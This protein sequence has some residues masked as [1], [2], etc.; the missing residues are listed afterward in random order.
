MASKIKILN[1]RTANPIPAGESSRLSSATLVLMTR[2]E[3]SGLGSAHWPALALPE[4][5][6]PLRPCSAWHRRLDLADPDHGI[7]PCRWPRLRRDSCAALGFKPPMTFGPRL[8]STIST[9]TEAPGHQRS[10]QLRLRSFSAQHQRPIA[11]LDD[12]AR[13]AFD[14]A[15]PDGLVFGNRVLQRPPVLMTANIVFPLCSSLPMLAVSFN[16]P[17]RLL[18]V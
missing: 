8:C 18:S 13:F 9:A 16:E 5:L 15:E 6:R 14:T 2:T 3:A 4:R 1:D 7:N 11:D 10:A 17:D 12:L